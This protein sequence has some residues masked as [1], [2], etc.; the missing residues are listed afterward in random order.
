MPTNDLQ[1]KAEQNARRAAR[2]KEKRRQ[3][4]MAANQANQQQQ[5]GLQAQE[6]V[7]RNMERFT[8]AEGGEPVGAP[9]LP[10]PLPHCKPLFLL[11]NHYSDLFSWIIVDLQAGECNLGNNKHQEGTEH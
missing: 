1:L 6:G 7:Q 8:Q 2:K 4:K 10:S 11:K 5:E 9:S 3:K